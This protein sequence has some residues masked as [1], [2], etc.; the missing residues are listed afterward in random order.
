MNVHCFRFRDLDGRIYPLA[1]KAPTVGAGL[2]HSMMKAAAQSYARDQIEL[3]QLAKQEKIEL[4]RFKKNKS[5]T[6]GALDAVDVLMQNIPDKDFLRA[7]DQL[8]EEKDLGDFEDNDDDLEDE[9]MT[10]EE[11]EDEEDLSD[12]DESED[13]ELDEEEEEEEDSEEDDDEDES[14][15]EEVILPVQKG[16][17]KAKSTQKPIQVSIKC[18]LLLW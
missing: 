3:S 16:K 14:E 11:G 10:D 18:L 2:T 6:R 15:E 7:E 5:D 12:E 8:N 1:L 4:K 9:E 13:E 17:S